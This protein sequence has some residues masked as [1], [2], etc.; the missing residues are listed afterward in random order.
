MGDSTPQFEMSDSAG[1]TI[2]TSGTVG[3]TLTA[4][5][6]TPTKVLSKY[7]VRCTIDQTPITKRLLV[8]LNSGT[9]FV[10]LSPG[11]WISGEIRGGAKTQIHI[12]GNVAS[13]AYEAILDL[14]P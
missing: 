10:T 2:Q 6:V 5:P 12:K 7:F 13:V 1:T 11:E 4:I 14:E 9:D 8:S 3:T